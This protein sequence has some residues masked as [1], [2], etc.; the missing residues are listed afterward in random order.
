MCVGVGVGVWVCGCV[1][2]C[3]WWANMTAA[4]RK[5]YWALVGGHGTPPT[6]D[7]SQGGISTQVPCHV[8]GLFVQHVM[9]SPSLLALLSF[10]VY[11]YTSTPSIFKENTFYVWRFRATCREQPVAVSCALVPRSAHDTKLN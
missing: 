10:Q 3:R 1:C 11:T 9:N 7:Q 8:T 2:V 5:D 4:E 6:D